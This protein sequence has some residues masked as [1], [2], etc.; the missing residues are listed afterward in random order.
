M[1][2]TPVDTEI[3]FSPDEIIVS[4]TDLKGRITYANDVFCRVAE[5]KTADVIGKPHNI[6]RHPDMP[7]SVFKLL[8]ETLHQEKEIF[9]YVKNMSATG[10]FYW[11]IAHVTPSWNAEGAVIGYHSNRRAPDTAMVREISKL[12]ADALAEEN[13]HTNPKAAADAGYEFLNA[14]VQAAAENYDEFVWKMVA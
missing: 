1:H 7:R 14:K 6:I 13:K 3:K 8:W 10:K 12:Y 2:I 5:M 11:V 9:A 4:K